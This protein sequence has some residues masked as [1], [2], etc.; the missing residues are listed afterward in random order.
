MLHRPI[1]RP[2]RGIDVDQ[3]LLFVVA[4]IGSERAGGGILL[5]LQ[6]QLVAGVSGERVGCGC[7]WRGREIEIEVG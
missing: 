1:D 4:K 2:V 3:E 7:T 6:R 5:Q